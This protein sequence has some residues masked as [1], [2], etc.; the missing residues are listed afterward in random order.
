MKI[1]FEDK[2]NKCNRIIGSIKKLSLK[3]PITCCLTI[4]K[5]FARPHLDYADMIYDKTGNES[6]KD[7]LEKVQYNAIVAFTGA[8]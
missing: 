6:F 1:Y 5:T 4:Y 7:W 2:I 3:L 8:I